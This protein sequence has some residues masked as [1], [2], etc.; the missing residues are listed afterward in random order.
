MHERQLYL[1]IIEI[2]ALRVFHQYMSFIKP[3]NIELF[4][5]K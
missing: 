4:I 3:N 2:H 5:A 1:S